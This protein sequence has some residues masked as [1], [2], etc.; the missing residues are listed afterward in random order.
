MHYPA[1]RFGCQEKLVETCVPDRGCH[2]TSLRDSGYTL[3]CVYVVALCVRHSG[4][5]EGK[6]ALDQH[7]VPVLLTVSPL[8]VLAFTLYP[9]KNQ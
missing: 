8:A 2:A 4:S 9:A 5:A 6:S 1:C 3:F 7:G